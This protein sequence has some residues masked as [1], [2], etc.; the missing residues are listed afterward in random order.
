MVDLPNPVFIELHSV[1]IPFA[2]IFASLFTGIRSAP[3]LPRMFIACVRMLRRVYINTSFLRLSLKPLY[4]SIYSNC[5]LNAMDAIF[6]YFSCNSAAFSLLP[7]L[8]W[9]S[10]YAAAM[11]MLLSRMASYATISC[12]NSSYHLSRMSRIFSS[13]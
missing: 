11:L 10:L 7:V 12:G 4:Q 9:M 13:G 2:S 6:M 3:A 1:S 5:S 8:S